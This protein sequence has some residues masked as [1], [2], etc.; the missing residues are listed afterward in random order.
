MQKKP[1]TDD[2]KR[3]HFQRVK[4]MSQKNFERYMN[5]VLSRSYTTAERHYEESIDIALP[6]RYQKLVR[7]QVEKIRVE[8]D[9]IDPMW[10]EDRA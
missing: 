8:W 7:A 3:R 1:W 10:I 6:P 5:I 9:G 4:S 2:D